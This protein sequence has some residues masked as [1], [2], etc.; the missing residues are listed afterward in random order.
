MKNVI[1]VT[2][3]VLPCSFGQ[4]RLQPQGQKVFKTLRPGRSGRSAQFAESRDNSTAHHPRWSHLAHPRTRVSPG[5]LRGTGVPTRSKVFT[6]RQV[7]SIE[8]LPPGPETGATESGFEPPPGCL[9]SK[10]NLIMTLAAKAA[11]LANQRQARAKRSSLLPSSS[12]SPR[13]QAH[14]AR[15]DETPLP[16]G[17]VAPNASSHHRRCVAAVSPC[18]R[19]TQRSGSAKL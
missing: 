7:E 2:L 18:T 13:K 14:G 11:Y 3:I 15:R 8:T 6:R 4:F 9:G 1:F 17:T 5:V 19:I 10:C 16:V 12:S